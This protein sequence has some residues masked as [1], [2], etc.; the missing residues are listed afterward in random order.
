MNLVFNIIQKFIHNDFDRGKLS[1]LELK[2][3]V[4]E[5]TILRNDDMQ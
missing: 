4:I 1:I 5:S 2:I 3:M